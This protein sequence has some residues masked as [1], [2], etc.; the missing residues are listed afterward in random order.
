MNI[1]KCT[2]VLSEYNNVSASVFIRSDDKEYAKE[3]ST[4]N[5]NIIL[6][7]YGISDAAYIQYINLSSEQEMLDYN[8][9]HSNLGNN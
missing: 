7:H 5:F 8:K 2:F 4:L 6:K 9:S 3:I 1:Y